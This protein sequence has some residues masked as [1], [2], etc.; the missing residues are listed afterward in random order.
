LLAGRERELA[1]LHHA[2]ALA[3]T[4]IRQLVFITGEAGLGKTAL[5]EAFLTNL[6]ASGPLWSG[7]GQCLDHYGAG[8]AYLPVLEALGRLCRGPDGQEVVALLGQQAPTWLVQ[9]PG[10]IPA[11]D[12][13]AVQRR[14]AGATRD[15]MLRELA[16][17]LELLTARQPLL[18]VLEDLHWSDPSTLDLLAALAHRREPAR[19]LVLGTYRPPDALQRG[20]PLPAVHHELQRHGHCLELPLSFLST[21]AVATYL[22]ACFP[23]AQLPAALLHLVQQ[24]TA[25]NPLF[26]VTLVEDW[27]RR[28]RLVSADGAWTLRGALAEVA[29]TMPESLR[30]M[31]EEQLERLS[32][33]EQ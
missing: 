12:L 26:L 3:L 11:D 23:Q 6:E 17:A 33:Q 15:R 20:H 22:T 8:E 29:S 19:L 14:S 13:E 32:P 30:Q 25:G 28:S 31:L 7:C 2:L 24:R 10:L 18:L 9:M 21:A 16:E 5:V 1:V 27:V 4:G